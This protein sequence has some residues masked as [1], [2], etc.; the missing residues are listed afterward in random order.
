M[1]VFPIPQLVPNR[2]SSV[3]VLN[4]GKVAG[5]T[6]YSVDKH[7]GLTA[8]GGL[9]PIPQTEDADPSPAPKGPLI[10]G[11]D[12][13]FNPSS[14]ALFVSVRSNGALPGLL[15]AYPVINHQVSTHHVVSFLPTIP[16]IFSLNF[17]DSSDTHLLATA[18][19]PGAPGAALLQ[20]SYPSLQ[21]TL[22]KTITIPGPQIATCW[23]AYAPHHDAVYIFDAAKTDISIL[24][25]ETGDVKGQ[26]HFT[27]PDST[28]VNPGAKDSKVH[29][30]YL[31]VLGQSATPK[32]YVF[33]IGG[34]QLLA[35]VQVFDSFETLGAI[36]G[37]L[38]LAIWPSHKY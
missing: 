4:A 38:G 28:S 36:P 30:N 6:C 16:L 3:C 12:I 37:W 22:A 33:K 27:D 35:Q 21:A 25:P 26:I 9:R 19:S 24:N 1:P 14:T 7:K 13:V 10:L 8:L 11:Q 23:A 2:S 5:V 20:V 34:P 29:G 32:I 18:P 17:L 31:Y 15:Y